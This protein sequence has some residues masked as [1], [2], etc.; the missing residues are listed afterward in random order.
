MKP[1]KYVLALLFSAML[2]SCSDETFS[3]QSGDDDDE[4]IIE[5]TDGAGSGSGSGD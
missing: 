4:P 5:G 3:P 2:L 1:F